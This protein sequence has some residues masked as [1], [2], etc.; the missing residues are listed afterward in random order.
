MV[1]R[2]AV[3]EFG[4]RNW[5][6]IAAKVPGKNEVQCLHRW[7]KVLN[8]LL[9][10][11][12]WTDEEDKK[13]AELVGKFGAKKWSLIA[14]HLPGRIGKQCRERWHNHLN[15][16]INKQPWSLEEDRNILTAH[17]QLGKSHLNIY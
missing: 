13:V 16:D 8:P 15:P 11:G 6:L 2:R 5:K 1:L 17:H 14:Q 9:T 3:A 4:G 12:P 7:T 10:K